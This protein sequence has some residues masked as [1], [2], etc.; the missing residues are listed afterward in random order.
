[1]GAYGLEGEKAPDDVAARAPKRKSTRKLKARSS[2][3]NQL[4]R[5]L[6]SFMWFFSR[7]ELVLFLRIGV[8][9]ILRDILALLVLALV[10]IVQ[11][12]C[13]AAV[14]SVRAAR[15]CR[16]RLAYSGEVQAAL[17][18]R[19]ADASVVEPASLSAATQASAEGDSAE[20]GHSIRGSKAA[21]QTEQDTASVCRRE[22]RASKTCRFGRKQ[23]WS[24]SQPFLA[25]RSRSLSSRAVLSTRSST[26]RKRRTVTWKLH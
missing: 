11:T 12:M 22:L 3:N 2:S 16:G 20:V 18:A 8:P 1:M 4:L 17:E 5:F 24:T 26:L 10:L 15:R 7:F 25:P 21:Q 13:V 9:W 19:S 14:T 6:A 23:S